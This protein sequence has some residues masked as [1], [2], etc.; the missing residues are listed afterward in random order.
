MTSNFEQDLFTCRLK[1]FRCGNSIEHLGQMYLT[2]LQLLWCFIWIFWQV[3]ASLQPEHSYLLRLGESWSDLGLWVSLRCH[4]SWSWP[5][6]FALASKTLPQTG[7]VAVLCLL[8]CRIS[9]CLAVKTL[10]HLLQSNEPLGKSTFSDLIFPSQ[11]GLFFWW[12]WSHWKGE[13]ARIFIYPKISCCTVT[14]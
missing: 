12:D 6:A 2:C 1:N 11:F 10:S 8:M 5:L 13:F 14:K 4:L 7:Q 3:N 9:L